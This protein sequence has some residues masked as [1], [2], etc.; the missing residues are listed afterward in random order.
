MS[1]NW[2]KIRKAYENHQSLHIR[3]YINT[4]ILYYHPACFTCER[5]DKVRFRIYR[6]FQIYLVNHWGLLNITNNTNED[7]E[8]LR[9]KILAYRD[10]ITK[11]IQKDLRGDIKLLLKTV[12]LERELILI[13]KDT[14]LLILSIAIST[15]NYIIEGLIKETYKFA[16]KSLV[17]E[18]NYL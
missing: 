4:P 5:E 18:G 10:N 8:K 9:I 15:E 12:V 2:K 14:A 1:N 16:H 3:E 11:S 17:E 13:I 7:F 6:N